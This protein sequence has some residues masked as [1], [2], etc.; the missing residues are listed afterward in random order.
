[1]LLQ[2]SLFTEKKIKGL[3]YLCFQRIGPDMFSTNWAWYVQQKN[4]TW[5]QVWQDIFY[6]SL[7]IWNCSLKHHL[8]RKKMASPNITFFSIEIPEVHSHWLASHSH[9]WPLGSVSSYGARLQFRG[10][11]S[12]LPLCGG[13]REKRKNVDIVLWI[14]KSAGA[15]LFNELR[16]VRWGVFQ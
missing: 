4:L 9:D 7:H 2:I 11:L 8:V 14:I 5:E 12:K 1:M 10:F 16:R 3:S 15:N 6:I 13:G